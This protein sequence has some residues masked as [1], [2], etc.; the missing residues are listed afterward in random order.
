M[1][2]RNEVIVHKHQLWCEVGLLLHKV[3]N[4]LVIWIHLCV[5]LWIFEVAELWSSALLVVYYFRKNY[6]IFANLMKLRI[7]VYSHT[8]QHIYTDE[9]LNNLSL[10]Y[11]WDL[12]NFMF[13]YFFRGRVQISRC[14]IWPL[15]LLYL[16]FLVSNFLIK[17]VKIFL[18]FLL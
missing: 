17:L 8:I 15:K 13:E 4:F 18:Y 7:I 6:T 5:S 14:R 1:N 10:L 9:P 12:S 3:E 2:F 16:F 11:I